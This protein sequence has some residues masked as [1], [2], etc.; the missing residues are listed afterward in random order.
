MIYLKYWLLTD[1]NI[2]VSNST[3]YLFPMQIMHS[4]SNA[5]SVALRT[6]FF[7]LNSEIFHHLKISIETLNIDVIE[8]NNQDFIS[9]LDFIIK[10]SCSAYNF[11]IWHAQ[12]LLSQWFLQYFMK[13]M[14]SYKRHIYINKIIM[15]SLYE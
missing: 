5:F 9:Y 8:K 10:Q 7:L 4:W 1:I 6:H 3:Q 13:K 14:N 12:H 2:I 11:F 15:F